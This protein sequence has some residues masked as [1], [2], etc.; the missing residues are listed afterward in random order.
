MD[1]LRTFYIVKATKLVCFIIVFVSY[2]S[3]SSSG[4]DL[5]KSRNQ[6]YAEGEELW[7][8]IT[9]EHI[10]AYFVDKLCWDGDTVRAFKSVQAFQYVKSGKNYMLLNE[11]TYRRSCVQHGPMCVHKSV[12]FSFIYH[13]QVQVK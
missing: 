8:P 1:A 9:Y 6:I 5:E 11:T 12:T 2:S 10:C 13:S 4:F 7:P 3:E